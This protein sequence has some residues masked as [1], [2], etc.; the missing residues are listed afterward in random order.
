MAFLYSETVSRSALGAFP[1]RSA[2]TQTEGKDE[3]LSGVNRWMSESGEGSGRNIG[4][5]QQSRTPVIMRNGCFSETR[6]ARGH[7]QPRSVSQTIQ[8]GGVD[9]DSHLLGLHRVGQS[10]PIVSQSM[11]RLRSVQPE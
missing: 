5:D 4:I 2:R 8:I 1:R 11:E 9:W 3:I 7:S 6:R 10:L